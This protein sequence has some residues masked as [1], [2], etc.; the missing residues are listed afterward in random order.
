MNLLDRLDMYSTISYG[1]NLTNDLWVK[2]LSIGLTICE[3]D[4]RWLTL[5]GVSVGFDILFITFQ[6]PFAEDRT[7]YERVKYCLPGK[8]LDLVGRLKGEYIARNN[9]DKGWPRD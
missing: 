5:L 8:A 7:L 4:L 3:G 6:S 2:P 1:L 9:I